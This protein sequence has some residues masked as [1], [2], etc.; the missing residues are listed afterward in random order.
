[1][2]I[3]DSSEHLRVDLTQ[4]P[5]QC[6][7]DSH[8]F[9]KWISKNKGKFVIFNT[10]FCTDRNKTLHDALLLL[11]KECWKYNSLTIVLALAIIFFIIFITAVLIYKQRWKLK[12]VY[13]IAKRKHMEGYIELDQRNS[14]TFDAF[15]SYKNEDRLFVFDH[16]ID[17]LEREGGL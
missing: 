5:L 7:C 8:T 11:N 15:V 3:I 17:E 9:M 10:Y 12:Y 13:Y 2:R 6:N 16:M 4:N 1:M 14:F